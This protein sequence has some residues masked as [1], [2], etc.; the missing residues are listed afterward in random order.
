[1]INS[2]DATENASTIYHE[3]VHTSQ[4]ASM[5]WRDKEHQAYVAEDRW[6]ITHGIGPSDPSFRTADAAGKPVTNVAA[7]RAMV[8]KE[9]PGVS[10]K[11]STGAH[12]EVLDKTPSGDSVVKRADGTQYTR[13]PKKGNSFPGDEMKVPATGIK[14]DMSQ[15]KCP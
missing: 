7:I 15:F 14:I 9:Y 11:S 3:G 4:P 12:E 2:D 5:K 10:V 8:D 6:R 1:M 13:K